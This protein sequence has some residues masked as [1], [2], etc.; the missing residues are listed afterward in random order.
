MTITTRLGAPI[1][2][3]H[4]AAIAVLALDEEVAGQLLAQLDDRELKA[5]SAAVDELDVVPAEALIG[6]LEDL[7]KA[8]NGPVSVSRTGGA[9]YVRR[10]AA[11]SLGEDRARKLFA[12]P[13]EPEL[14]PIQ[15]LRSARTQALADLL[16]EEH[17]QIA[18][19]VLTQLP[20]RTAAKILQSLPAEIAA[21]LTGRLADL[22]EV[23]DRAVLEASDSLVRA[24]AATG[25]LQSSDQ[26]SEFDGLAFAAALVNEMT[27]DEGD[28]LL[29]RVGE[30]DAA[31]A[32]RVREAMFTFDDLLRID[33]RSLGPLLR[34]VQGE[35]MVIALQTASEELRDHFFGALSQR[36]AQTMR[37]DLEASPP[38]RV[39]EVEAAQREIVEAAMRLAA[40]GQLQLPPRGGEG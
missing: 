10:L 22:E 36:A 5:L 35:S 25:G 37:E 27:T 38:K 2:P 1:G 8:M 21:D 12:P 20:A 39:A 11:S 18:A 16:A 15:Q 4:K 28:A 6:V 24:L 30:R 7:E 26:R 32:S 34:A 23:P 33:Q 19:V 17:P 14:E 9:A 40:E 29:A 13:A 31:I 3:R